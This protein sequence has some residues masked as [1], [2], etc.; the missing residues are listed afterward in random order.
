MFSDIDWPLNASRGLSAIVGFLVFYYDVE[1]WLQA[2]LPLQPTHQSDAASN[3]SR[4]ALLY[5]GLVAELWRRFCSQL[6]WSLGCSAATN[7]EV[8]R[9]DHDLWE[10]STFG[11]E[12]AN[13]AQTCLG[14][15]SMRKRTARNFFYQNRCCGI[16]T[17][18]TKSLQTSGK[19][20]SRHW[21]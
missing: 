21:C 19:L 3:P 18:I 7:L 16:A 8:Y 17:Y 2:R 14:K 15:H 1:V 12:V 20:I 11:V 6:D 13:D 5:S 9:G 10:Y 4:P